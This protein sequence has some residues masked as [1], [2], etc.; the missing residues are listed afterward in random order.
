[1]KQ[2]LGAIRQEA[3]TRTN[4]E[5]DPCRNMASLGHYELI[6]MLVENANMSGNRQICQEIY[7]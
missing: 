1:M 7:L 4:V 6:I 5:S 2:N 3:I